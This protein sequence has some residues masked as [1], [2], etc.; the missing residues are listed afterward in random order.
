MLCPKC[1]RDMLHVVDSRSLDEI[2]IYRRRECL[3]CGHRFNTTEISVDDY[4][5][6]EKLAADWQ[7]IAQTYLQLRADAMSQMSQEMLRPKFKQKR[8][9]L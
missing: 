6:L 2:S 5:R 9:G 4:E 8:G 7:S 3:A 1:K